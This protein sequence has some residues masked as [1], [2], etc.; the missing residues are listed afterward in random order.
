M[1]TRESSMR[2]LLTAVLMALSAAWAPSVQAQS[3]EPA[4]MVVIFDGSGSMWGKPDGESK[5][6]LV[7]ARDALRMSLAKA[8][9]ET[10][11]GLM[12]YGHRRSAD[13]GDVETIVKPEAGSVERISAVLE[14]HNPRGRGPITQALREAAKELGGQSAPASVVLI[15]DDLD[16]CQS[17]PCSAIGELRR[18]HPKVAVHVVSMGMRREDHQRMSC[19]ATQTGGTLSEVANAA[20]TTA[21]FEM[22]FRSASAATRPDTAKATPALT[23]KASPNPRPTNPGLHLSATLAAGG[24]PITT[25]LRWRVSSAEKPGTSPVYEGDAASPS[26]TL[27]AGR[28]DI[29]AQLGFVLVR[30]SAQIAENA[31]HQHAVALG[32]GTIAMLAA[33]LDLPAVRDA[34]MTLARADAAPDSNTVVMIRGIPAEV[35]LLPGAYRMTVQAGATRIERNVIVALGQRLLLAPLLDFGELTLSA[36]PASG[37]QPLDTVLFTVSE[38]DPDAPQGR[39]EIVRSAAAQPR[40]LLPPGAYAVVARAAN[41]E[42]RERLTIK[43]GERQ[44]KS[45]V[46]GLGRVAVSAT[47]QGRAGL[48]DAINIRLDAIDE[49]RTSTAHG[50]S[51]VFDVTAGRYRVEARIGHGNAVVMREFEVKAGAREQI[52]IDIPAGRLQLR[53]LDPQRAT[54]Q[55]DVAWD[56]RDAS[57][58]SVWTSHQTEALP[59]LLQGRYSV[60]AELRG[61]EFVRDVEVR[62]GESRS[63]DLVATP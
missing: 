38:D 12:S 3:T 21:A 18:A 42:V 31:A 43:S 52:A 6:K 11:I 30:S 24:E 5:T 44:Q 23:Q 39:R 7:L 17:D 50:Q 35:T 63:Y 13:C 27:P 62:A 14:K 1:A 33:P 61:R 51:A 55:N 58:K 19:L 22:I 16:N 37:G 57:G 15:H 40:L 49:R 36:I 59:L 60:R 48:K 46:L 2:T 10:R 9:P 8:A 26:L 56:I 54:P 45:L 34:V 53:L 47:M 4:T 41:A 20:Q 29:E 25:P 32:A 28:Y